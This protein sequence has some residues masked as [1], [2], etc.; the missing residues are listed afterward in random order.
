[1]EKPVYKRQDNRQVAVVNMTAIIK[2]ILEAYQSETL[3]SMADKIGVSL[4]TTKRWYR[5]GKA[6]Q[7]E[8]NALIAAYP[9]SP[10]KSFVES[11]D[12]LAVNQTTTMVEL[13]DQVFHVLSEIRKRLGV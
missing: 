7:K 9:I 8:A 6:R 4:G 11:N 10:I 5:T 13:F 1:M 2:G 3:V 12:K